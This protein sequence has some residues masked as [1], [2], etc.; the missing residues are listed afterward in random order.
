MKK[1]YCLSKGL[2][3]EVLA[4]GLG[5]RLGWVLLCVCGGVGVYRLLRNKKTSSGA[6]K[7][8][9]TRLQPEV[10]SKDTNELMSKDLSRQ[11]A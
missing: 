5:S 1:M 4:L 11:N 3:C 10:P 8:R 9:L 2:T 6:V 7:G